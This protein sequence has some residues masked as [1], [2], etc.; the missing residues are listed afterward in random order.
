MKDDNNIRLILY[1]INPFHPTGPFFTLVL[2]LKLT[3]LIVLLQ[4][5]ERYLD[6]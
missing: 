5:R 6:K 2:V 4:F 3:N 1:T